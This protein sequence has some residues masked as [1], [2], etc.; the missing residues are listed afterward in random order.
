[1]VWQHIAHNYLSF[2]TFGNKFGCLSCHI[3][4]LNN[5]NLCEYFQ[6]QNFRKQL[7]VSSE[8]SH[9]NKGNSINLTHFSLI[10]FVRVKILNEVNW[11]FNQNIISST[12]EPWDISIFDIISEVGKIVEQN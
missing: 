1:M 7:K 12:V 6:I 9:L 8:A 4:D 3:N 11:L 5:I 2:G 10:K